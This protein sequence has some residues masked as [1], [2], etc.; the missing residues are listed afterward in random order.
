MSLGPF[1]SPA[2]SRE[3]AAPKVAGR[4]AKRDQVTNG[5]RKKRPLN[6]RRRSISR[7]E[8]FRSGRKCAVHK[9]A[10]L[11]YAEPPHCP[12]KVGGSADALC[13]PFSSLGKAA[14]AL[15]ILGLRMMRTE[16]RTGANEG[17]EGG[18]DGFFRGSLGLLR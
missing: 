1:E 10:T 14:A 12:S 9:V 17:N 5:D 4:A 7:R 16:I 13:E 8:E 18:D 11:A 2:R 15:Q 6:S 3:T